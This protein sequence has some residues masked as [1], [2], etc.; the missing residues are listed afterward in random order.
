M[1]EQNIFDKNQRELLES[2]P[3]PLIIYTYSN[4]EFKPIIISDSA[5]KFFKLDKEE[6]KISISKGAIQRI[7]YKELTSTSDF[8]HTLNQSESQPFSF[9]IEIPSREGSRRWINIIGESRIVKNGTVLIYCTHSDISRY[10]N[11]KEKNDI[12]SPF[13]K[14][15]TDTL[16]LKKINNLSMLHQA[17]IASNFFY[18]V[19]DVKQDVVT[20]GNCFPEILGQ[21]KVI[22][23]YPQF[24]FDSQLIP[25]KEKNKY[26]TMLQRVLNGAPFSEENI[27]TYKPNANK[28]LLDH[29]RLFAV[30]DDEGKTALVIGTT[31]SYN[32]YSNLTYKTRKILNDFGIISWTYGLIEKKYYFKLPKS[33]DTQFLNKSN[34]VYEAAQNNFITI[35][36]SILEGKKATDSQNVTLVDENGKDLRFTINFST[37]ED[38]N[39]KPYAILCVA[40]DVTQYY[41]SEINQIKIENTKFDKKLLFA[42]KIENVVRANINAILN[43]SNF[44]FDESKERTIKAY[45]KQIQE[46]SEAIIQFYDN[47]TEAKILEKQ[48]FT[49]HKTTYKA[50]DIYN[51]ILSVVK[52]KAQEKGVNLKINNRISNLNMYINIDINK[53]KKVYLNLLSNAIKF[54]PQGGTVTF[55]I[56]SMMLKSN[57]MQIISVISDNGVGMSENFQKI[58]YYKYTQEQNS[59]SDNKEKGAGLGLSIVKKILDSYGH[60]ITCK[61][62]LGVGTSF[63]I[64]AVEELASQAEIEIFNKNSIPKSLNHLKGKTIMLCDDK[65]INIMIVSK[66]LKQ[67]GIEVEFASNGLIGV[68]LA[69]NNK[70][71][72]I[73]M[74]IKMPIMDGIT[75]TTKIREFDKTIPIIA[76]SSSSQP[77]DIEKALAHGMD[78]Y[79]L[80][81]I[82]KKELYETLVSYIK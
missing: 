8:I 58:M 7:F 23:N 36:Q 44:G 22:H 43:L 18:W 20:S 11:W 49:N 17:M 15:T 81:P 4:N 9:D 6:L 71:D 39:Q 10:S 53:T 62:Q 41:E 56:N 34:L 12:V 63:T 68:N 64:T 82:N 69:R 29:Y 1:Q 75:A 32:T 16:A 31:E 38:K 74:D 26:T 80:K 14:D 3:S 42:N 48:N 70:L 45:F 46:S 25:E 52:R 67:I 59:K 33:D 13:I 54:T 77:D 51:E 2:L 66:L 37:I 21:N 24:L 79:L 55:S 27:L 78:A 72:G 60:Q 35:P 61:S 57:A 50:G 19:Y 30:Y 5:A 65:N 73:L 76:L 40:R 47:D 28:Y